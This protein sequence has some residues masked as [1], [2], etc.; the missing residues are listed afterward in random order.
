MLGGVFM[1]WP[2]TSYTAKL[3]FLLMVFYQRAKIEPNAIKKN[4]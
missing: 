1:E 2:V 3:S 4:P